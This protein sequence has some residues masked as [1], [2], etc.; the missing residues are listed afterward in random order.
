MNIKEVKRTSISDQIFKQLKEN[1]INGTLKPNDKLPSENELCKLYS[2]SRTT[3]RQALVNLQSLDLIET[4][5]G[6]G[7]FVKKP[8]Q[9]IIVNNL[10]PHTYLNPKSIFEIVEFRQLIEPNV[11][12]MACKKANLDDI[13]YLEKIYNEMLKAKNDLSEFSKLDYDFHI[14]IAKISKNSYVIRIYEIIKDVLI[15]AFSEIVIKRGNFAGLKYHKMI[16]SG[17]KNKDFEN[18][19]KAMQEH[20]DDLAFSYN[21]ISN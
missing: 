8:N 11:A 3:I 20:M 16:L 15:N 2:V 18:V 6:K 1:I 21:K 5:F 7:S 9:A 17:F 14:A 4:K 19:K 13:E 12:C 10:I